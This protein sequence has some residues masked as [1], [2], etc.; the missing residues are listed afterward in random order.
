MTVASGVPQD[1]VLS[2]S[3]FL[4][5]ITDLPTIL[6][7]SQDIRVQLYADDIQIYGVCDSRNSD[8]ACDAL[9]HLRSIFFFFASTLPSRL[10]TVPPFP[11][12]EED[13]NY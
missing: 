4:I 6:S 11:L 3:L 1:G 5:Y 7:P 9:K 12:K 10:L 8:E 13:S 2:S